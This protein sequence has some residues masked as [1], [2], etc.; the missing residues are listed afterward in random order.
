MSTF[1]GAIK[2]KALF[3]AWTTNNS[4]FKEKIPWDF[5]CFIVFDE[6]K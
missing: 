5:R 1:E 2:E 6:G 3:P 4:N